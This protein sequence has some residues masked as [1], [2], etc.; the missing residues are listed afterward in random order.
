[1]RRSFICIALSVLLGGRAFFGDG[2]RTDAAPLSR[3][4]TP[5]RRAAG[6]AFKRGKQLYASGDY[7][8]ALAAFQEGYDAYP[9][10]GFL[11]NV[12]QCQRKLGHLKE[13][14]AAFMS[15]L[16]G[17]IASALRNEVEEALA[18]VRAAEREIAAAAPPTPEPVAPEAPPPA[19]VEPE[20]SPALVIAA[21]PPAREHRRVK[22]WGWA[23]I[24][25][26]IGVVAAGAAVGVVFGIKHSAPSASLG[27][28][29]T[30]SQ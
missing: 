13:A 17:Q 19:V 1:L 22:A 26:S 4:D 10:R 28:I 15:V 29:D 12:G 14:E 6:A 3:A 5:Q 24:G 18:E 20:S 23:L 25:I 2:A 9:L 30:R 16:D 8:A 7:T 11:V 21:A 27:V